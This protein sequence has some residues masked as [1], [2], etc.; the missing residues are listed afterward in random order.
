MRK[1]VVTLGTFDGVH[2]GHQA[3]LRKVVT[4]ARAIGAQ[5]VALTFD[6]PP[7][8]TG[9][10]VARPVLLTTLPE[11]VQLIKRQGIRHIPILV[12]NHKTKSTSP[13]N[14]FHQTLLRRWGAR[15]MVVGPKVAFG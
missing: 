11:K 9:E 1:S 2:R 3:L 15:E 5:S 10:P 6:L 13:E 12:F 7:R 4:R 8:H 14:F